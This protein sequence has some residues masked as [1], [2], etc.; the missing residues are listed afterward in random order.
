M[1]LFLLN[2]YC[3]LFCQENVDLDSALKIMD[4]QYVVDSSEINI[5]QFNNNKNKNGHWVV[6]NK[7][8]NLLRL[9]N[10]K[11]GLL[12]G[13]VFV[14]NENGILKLELEFK[15]NRLNGKSK[16]YSSKGDLLAIFNYINNYFDGSLYYIL[17]AESPPL[18]R[19]GFIPKYK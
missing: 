15:E 19:H 13:R 7:K 10:Y 2:F 3:E 16:F 1:M 8:G 11:D 17:D 4:I 14:F 9:E 12:N 18:G 5:G 6:F